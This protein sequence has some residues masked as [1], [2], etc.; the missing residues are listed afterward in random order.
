MELDLESHKFERCAKN[1]IGL[2][3]VLLFIMV[4]I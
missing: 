4:L 2:Q 1:V 3:I